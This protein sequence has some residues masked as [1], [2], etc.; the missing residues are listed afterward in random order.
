MKKIKVGD[1]VCF[2]PLGKEDIVSNRCY[3]L[4]SEF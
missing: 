1:I 3:A 4:P 2:L